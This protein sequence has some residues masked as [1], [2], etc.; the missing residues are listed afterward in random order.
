MIIEHFDL[1]RNWQVNRILIY[2]DEASNVGGAI[3][4]WVRERNEQVIEICIN[5]AF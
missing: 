3:T 4:S 5:G 2:I 1:E